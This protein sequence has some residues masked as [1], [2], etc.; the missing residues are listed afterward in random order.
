MDKNIVWG[1]TMN[2]DKL[3]AHNLSSS[4]SS[5][6]ST[7]FASIFSPSSSSVEGRD[8]R[9]QDDGCKNYELP[10]THSNIGESNDRNKSTSTNY[11]NEAVEPS[12]FSSSIYYGGQENYSPRIRTT[13]PHH[14]IFKKDKDDDPNGK[15]SNSTS[16][17]NWWEGSLYY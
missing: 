7:L 5:S 10:G 8:A 13:E 17:G 11:Q 6:S 1:S 2:F 16:R 3:F 4:T 9:T 15:E 12:Y 14:V